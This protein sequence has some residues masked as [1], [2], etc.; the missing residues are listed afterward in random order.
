[1][2]S[3]AH[4][5]LSHPLT[6]TLCRHEIEGPHCRPVAD[7]DQITLAG[8]EARL[9]LA[10]AQQDAWRSK[11][12]AELQSAGEDREGRALLMTSLPLVTFREKFCLHGRDAQDAKT[13]ALMNRLRTKTLD[14][15]MTDGDTVQ[16][17]AVNNAA[18]MTMGFSEP[19]ELEE[20]EAMMFDCD[21]IMKD[22]A[23]NTFRITHFYDIGD[24][25][26]FIERRKGDV[27]A[28]RA[29]MYCQFM[30]EEWFGVPSI[31]TN[32]GIASALVA[33]YGFQHAAAEPDGAC[34]VIDMHIDKEA[35]NRQY[36]DIITD[37]TLKREGLRDYLACHIESVI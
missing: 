30:C 1:M 24:Q 14:W 16:I 2:T 7:I 4:I 27:D 13:M 37:A 18:L 5:D 28:R 31:V 25:S 32:L 19:W 17:T 15:R 35:A 22:K 23:A 9:F 11:V 26:I 36:H 33:F 29:A 3:L 6:L 12:E 20:Y 34:G 10:W 8:E 21:K